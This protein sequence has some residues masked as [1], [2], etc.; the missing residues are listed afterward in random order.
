MQTRP[1]ASTSMALPPTSQ[2]SFPR[3][4]SDHAKSVAFDVNKGVKQEKSISQKSRWSSSRLDL[5]GRQAR[6]VEGRFPSHLGPPRIP[7]GWEQAQQFKPNKF[8]LRSAAKPPV[9]G[10]E[11]SYLP[12]GQ[13]QVLQVDR[14]SFHVEAPTP[15]ALAKY[16]LQAEKNA[17]G[18]VPSAGIVATVYLRFRNGFGASLLRY[19][20]GASRRARGQCRAL[21]IVG[22]AAREAVLRLP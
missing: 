3:K 6:G 7:Y 20:P 10:K 1:I 12:A 13:Q 4:S 8:P 15:E 5:E 21:G 19:G 16:S 14:R 11:S 9:V 2:A 17:R 22:G 18:A